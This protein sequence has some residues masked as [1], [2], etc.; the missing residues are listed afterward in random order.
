MP[1]FSILAFYCIYRL[2]EL[3]QHVY[4]IWDSTPVSKQCGATYFSCSFG[5]NDNFGTL[6][7]ALNYLL[8]PCLPI[9]LNLKVIF[10]WTCR[11][12]WEYKK[13][14]QIFILKAFSGVH[15]QDQAG[16]ERSC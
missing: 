16:E 14:M 15:L 12:E 4:S 9:V 10:G 5:M 11:L 7:L 3:Y 6:H 13:C 8:W 2:P 1:P